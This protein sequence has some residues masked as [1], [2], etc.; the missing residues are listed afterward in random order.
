MLSQR[1]FGELGRRDRGYADF[2]GDRQG[3]I[4][5]KQKRDTNKRIQM[6]HTLFYNLPYTVIMRSIF[7]LRA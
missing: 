4:T 7:C 3:D 2:D 1:Q 5:I 6:Q